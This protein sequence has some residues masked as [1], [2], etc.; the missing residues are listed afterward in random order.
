MSSGPIVVCVDGSKGSEHAFKKVTSILTIMM[1][2][3]QYKQAVALA[4]RSKNKIVL[5]SVYETTNV[6]LDGLETPLAAREMVESMSKRDAYVSQK[7]REIQQAY[8]SVAEKEG[9]S[10]RGVVEETRNINERLAT[11]AE[12]VDAQLLVVGNRGFG[13]IKVC[14]LGVYL[15]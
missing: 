12:N 9:V 15:I 6:P 3:L 8:I 7:L 10:C 2:C 4:K 14:F 1:L 5:A 11:I 13:A